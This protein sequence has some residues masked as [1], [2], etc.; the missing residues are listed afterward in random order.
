VSLGLT[1]RQAAS[2]F[3]RLSRAL[4]FTRL[5][6]TRLSRALDEQK[7]IQCEEVEV[8]EEKETL[9]LCLI[10][11]DERPERKIDV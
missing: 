7:S 10:K 4:A 5:S 8:V 1:V 11:N 2:A 9:S 6:F 3:T